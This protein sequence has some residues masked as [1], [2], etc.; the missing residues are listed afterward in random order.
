MSASSVTGKGVGAADDGIKG[1]G[2]NRNYFVPEVNPHVVCADHA[3]VAGGGTILVTFPSPLPLAA[4]NYMVLLTPLVS[5]SNDT[6]VSTKTDVDGKFA[7]FI[8]TGAAGTCGW[9][10]VKRGFGF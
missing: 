7:S 1:P 10:V 6:Y 3:T 4:A 9:V 8:I 2:N 5:N